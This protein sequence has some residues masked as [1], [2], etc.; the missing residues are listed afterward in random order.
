MANLD[1]GALL[2][3]PRTPLI[4]R[5]AE[6]ALVRGLLARDDAPLVTLAGPGGVGKTRLALAVADEAAADFPDGV[7]RVALA[8]IA[9]PALVL[10]TIARALGVGEGSDA[11]APDR[12]RAVLADRRLLLLLDNVEQ[13]VAAAPAL[14]ALLLACR[15]LTVLATSR[16][17]LRIAGEREVPVP[18]LAIP[19]ATDGVAAERLTD[20]PAVRLFVA[21]TEAILPA[22]RLTSENAAAVA[23]ICHRLDGLPLAIELAAALGK[24]L[25]PATLLTRLERRLPF[26]V[27]GARDLPARQRTMRDAIAWSYNLLTADEA[28]L[29]RALS[30]FAGGF[31]LDAAEAV[32]GRGSGVGGVVEQITSDSRLPTAASVV[33]LVAAL[34]DKSLLRPIAAS[35]AEPRFAMLETIREFGLEQLAARAELDDARARHAAYFLALAEDAEPRLRGPE[36]LVQLARLDAEHDNLRAALAW[37]LQ[38]PDR[39]PIAL[40]LTAAL[41]WF[42]Y[43]RGHFGEG[44][45]WLQTALAQPAPAVSLTRARTLAGAGVLDFSQGDFPAARQALAQSIAI[46]CELRDPATVAYGL[47]SLVAGDLPHADVA[48]LREQSAESVALFRETGD[49]WG[50]AMALRTQGLVAIVAGEVD[51]AA[52]P[53][54]ESLALSRELGDAW[55]LARVLHYAGE[56]AR[57]CGDHDRAR[58]LYA[59]SLALY[60]GL[61]LRH[62]AAIVLHNLGYVASRQGDPR[63]GMAFFAEALTRQVEHE[64]RLNVA[65][66]LA[67]IAGMAAALGQPELATRLLGAATALLATMDAAVWP[68]DQIEYDRSL[69]GVREQLGAA[70]FAAAF[71]AGQAL[72]PQDAVAEALAAA[73]A[74]QPARSPETEARDGFGLT[75]RETD[76]LRLLTRRATDRE[77]ADQ[78]SISPRTVMHHVS[79]VLAKL[80]VANRREAA[81]VAVRQ[82]LVS[83]ASSPGSPESAPPR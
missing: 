59:E 52:E 81:D 29:F 83:P 25:P 60:Q 72:S 56:L 48:L 32:G 55:L 16:S 1:P 45:R 58:A 24:L 74:A 2:V 15:G 39:A 38:A 28:R 4:G 37:S 31:T 77:I 22:F 57:F 66:C 80:G 71:A 8:S 68:V 36:Q 12:V 7:V 30:V 40:R 78:L 3:P 18:P 20:W 63:R 82:G 5:E 70:R 10:P 14:A 26:L 44:L 35:E 33:T 50:L 79:R 9:D 64:D 73:A 21:R 67:G 17:P 62:T 46:G 76:V 42:W 54:A 41:A 47:Q 34:V 53:F 75:P 61:G 51:R 6:S 27:D 23:A 49:R 19:P 65:H 69:A 43:L 11:A 13:V